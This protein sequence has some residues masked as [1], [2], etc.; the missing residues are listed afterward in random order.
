VTRL[1]TEGL[2]TFANTINYMLETGAAGVTVEWKAPKTPF[3]SK[4]GR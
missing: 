4:T 3:T 2:K 1:S